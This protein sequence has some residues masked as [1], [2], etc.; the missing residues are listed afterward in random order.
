[1]YNGLISGLSDGELL[2]HR[3][4][5]VDGI[6]VGLI[7]QDATKQKYVKEAKDFID[8]A[9]ISD[10][11][12]RRAVNNL[13]K[14]LKANNLWDK[15][16]AIYP[17]VGGNSFS[18]KFN[19]KN[20]IDADSAFR[21][22]FFGTITHSPTGMVGDGISGYY[23]TNL[24]DSLNF[25][26]DSVSAWVYLRTNMALSN[27]ADLNAGAVIGSTFL[28]SRNATDTFNTRAH[29]TNAD[30]LSNTDSRGFFGVSRNIAAQYRKWKNSVNTIV[31]EASTGLSNDTYK[32]MYYPTGGAY[33]SR[34]QAF[35]A[36][37][38]GL[39]STEAPILYSIVQDFQTAL[40]RQV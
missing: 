3:N 1:M 29:S 12:H 38:T 31:V 27:T 36:I 14:N 33:N 22:T 30:A 35:S 32:G 39:L 11:I 10:G 7:G 17:M 19:L 16:I 15:F 4:G 40:S 24:N 2:V 20:P 25:T 8:A 23:D 28:N 13:V 5:L 18:H 21:L 37:G 6:G 9:Q 26:Q 34:E